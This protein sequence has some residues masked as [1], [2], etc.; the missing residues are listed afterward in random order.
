MH[1]FSKE[2]K[3]FGGHGIVGAQI[4]LGG[5]MPLL[6][7]IVKL[8]MFVPVSLETVQPGRVPCMRT[9]NMAMLWKLPVLFI[10]ENNEYAMGTSVNGPVM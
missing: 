3:F 5:G 4:P 9:F 7:N 1:F 10:C 2:K 6:K 8:V